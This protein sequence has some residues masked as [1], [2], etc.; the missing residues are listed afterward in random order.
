MSNFQ[1]FGQGTVRATGGFAAMSLAY[2]DNQRMKLIEKLRPLLRVIGHEGQ[3]RER[4]HGLIPRAI[5]AG[6]GR[7]KPVTLSDAAQVLVGDG[8][9]M[10]EGVEKDGVGGLGTDAGK[11]QQS[12]AQCC[13]R[14]RGEAFERAAEL[15][16][17]HGYEGLECR[18][19]ARM[20]AGG[21]D[22][23]LQFFERE[24]AQAFHGEGS[25][26]AQIGERAFDGLPSGVLREIGAEDD[27]K[28]SL[29][30]PPVLRAVSLEELVVH[31]AEA[32][33]GRG[34][35]LGHGWT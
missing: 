2:A 30:R 26:C 14:S 6:R 9:G 32:L 8:N 12:K 29:G 16:V 27:L 3:T 18:S 11:S 15:L 24:R 35:G 31:P 34:V 22:E 10:A 23:A 5:V 33:G 19:L 7:Q 4:S 28:G 25:G 21:L 1:I 13:C 17:E 20:K